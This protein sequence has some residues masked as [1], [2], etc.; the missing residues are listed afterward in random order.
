MK[1]ILYTI[2][3]ILT[4]VACRQSGYL[5]QGGE[6]VLELEVSRA[7]KPVVASR[8]VEEDLAVTVLDANGEEYLY[9]PAGAVPKKIVLEPGVFTVCAHTENLT[10]W[11][12]ANDGKGEPC[13]FAGQRVELEYDHRTRISIS[14][15]MINYAVGVELPDLF[16]NLFGSYRFTLKSGSR[17]VAVRE[18]EKAYF[19]LSDGGFFYTLSAT[20]ADGVSH[21]HSPVWFFDVQGGKHYLLRYHYDSD[22]TSGGVDIEITDDMGTDDT[23]IDL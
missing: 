11:H 21:T 14:V 19:D 20:N 10:T 12:T 13:Y 5:E 23:Y 6:C 22:A 7:D 3:S 8:A 4:L 1:R 2:L 9:F 15:P 17:E 16:D 18:G